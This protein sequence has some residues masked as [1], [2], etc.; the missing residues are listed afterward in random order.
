MQQITTEKDSVQDSIQNISSVSEQLAASTQ[1]VTATLGEQT[2]VIS[3]LN[4]KAEE[5]RREAKGLDE[6]ISRFRL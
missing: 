6:S 3:Q 4:V 2:E 1:E 5:L